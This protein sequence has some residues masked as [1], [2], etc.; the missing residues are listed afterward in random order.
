[1]YLTPPP[2]HLRSLAPLSK[3]AIAA[4]EL[5]CADIGVVTPYAAQARL[6]RQLWRERCQT[7]AAAGGKGGEKG[8]RGGRG[9]RGRRRARGRSA[10]SSPRVAGGRV[11]A[12]SEAAENAASR[13][14]NARA[15]EI[16]SVDAFQGREKELI[17]FSAV[18]K[19]L[20]RP[21][22]IVGSSYDRPTRTRATAHVPKTCDH[23]HTTTHLSLRHRRSL[24]ST[25]LPRRAQVR[26][27]PRGDVGF[28]ADWR[29]LN[30]MLTRARRGLVVIGSASTLARGDPAG[31]GRWLAWCT[32]RGFIV[33]P[34]RGGAD[35]PTP[36]PISHD[37]VGPP[38]SHSEPQSP[39][40]ETQAQSKKEEEK[41][42]EE[43][44]KKKTKKKKKKTTK[45]TAP[46]A[47]ENDDGGGLHSEQAPECASTASPVSH[48]AVGPPSSHSELQSPAHETQAQ[49]KKE[50]EK[51]KKKKKKRKKPTTGSGADGHDDDDEANTSVGTSRTGAADAT[52]EEVDD[53]ACRLAVHPSATTAAVPKGAMR[54]ST[55]AGGNEV[56]EDGRAPP[57]KKKKRQTAASTVEFGSKLASSGSGRGAPALAQAAAPEDSAGASSALASSRDVLRVTPVS[58]PAECPRG[59]AADVAAETEAAH[60][61]AQR[62]SQKKLAEAAAA[63]VPRAQSSAQSAKSVL[64]PA[65]S[66]QTPVSS[67]AK[68]KRK[69]ASAVAEEEAKPKPKR[70]KASA[71]VGG[72]A[73]R[74]SA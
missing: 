1:M 29:R 42:K 11:A 71:A 10:S 53:A 12:P 65:S 21:S 16:A 61:V 33:D 43:E 54:A 51:E 39:A 73:C 36:P 38:P 6:L 44:E 34:A 62:K 63:V 8:G 48:D 7:A 70:K 49:A 74:H 18:R 5:G 30:V 57:P 68:P 2:S 64:L 32:A 66:L 72:S 55:A 59:A 15:L 14:S 46:G 20:N 26:D 56:H 9:A 4:G 47:D 41:E 50:E 69:K 60:P 23:L 31:W 3:D 67:E 19:R 45:T 25:R 28:L 58:V 13:L 17:V 22:L 24:R 27:N 35:A 40:H 37:A 52:G